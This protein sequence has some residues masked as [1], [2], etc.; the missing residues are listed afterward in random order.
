MLVGP[1]S[2][3]TRG[4]KT[5][6]KKREIYKSLIDSVVIDAELGM[7]DHS[8]IPA[9]AI[10]KRLKPLDVRTEL[11]TRLDGP[12]GRILVIKKKEIWKRDKDGLPHAICAESRNRGKND[13]HYHT[14]SV[15]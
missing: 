11:R 13:Y 5:K 3:G 4:L 2:L 8:S 7:E 14:G 10:R 15:W 1:L 9:T 6:N 12:V